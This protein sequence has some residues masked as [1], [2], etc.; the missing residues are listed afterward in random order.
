MRLLLKKSYIVANCEKGNTV[1]KTR[2]STLNALKGIA[3]FS[4]VMLHCAFPGMVGKIIYGIARF[5]V[6]L[7]FAISGYYVYS[8]N[9]KDVIRRLPKKIEHIVL[10]FLE[11][12]L[13]YGLWH[14]IQYSIQVGT[15]HG[16]K[17]WI[18]SLLSTRNILYF[19]VFQ[20]TVIGDVS[21]FL[22]ALIWCY[23]VTFAIAKKDIWT[24]TFLLIPILLLLNV[25]LGEVAPFM[26]IK[27]EWYWCSNFWLLGFPCYALGYYIKINEEK[28]TRIL[29]ESTIITI[30]IMSVLLNLIERVLTNASQLFVSNI[31]FMIVCFVY[32]IKFPIIFQNN[33]LVKA[34]SIIGEKCSFGVYILHPIIR[35]IFRMLAK[36][37]GIASQPIWNWILPILVFASSVCVNL[38]WC[39][40][41]E[42]IKFRKVNDNLKEMEKL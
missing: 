25:F 39:A 22:V 24:K 40:G 7:F 29:T 10:L 6:P 12:E 38:L 31:P 18:L 11:T 33:K 36:Y 28:M 41:K 34:I 15:I 2:N 5:A 3:C 32:C 16:A 35:D 21:W 27:T 14:C 30:I 37:F 42:K 17:E 20:R 9:S 13:I 19:I 23:I 26:G 1:K 4:V 8:C